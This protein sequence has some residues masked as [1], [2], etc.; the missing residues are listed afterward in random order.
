MAPVASAPYKQILTVGLWVQLSLRQCF[1]LRPQFSD[2]SKKSYQ[3]SL[4]PA[5]SYCKDESHD[6]YSFYLS[7]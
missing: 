6:F 4:Y 5:F 3:F 2:G 7:E 1:V